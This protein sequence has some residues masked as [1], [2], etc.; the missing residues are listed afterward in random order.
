MMKDTKESGA[1][2]NKGPKKPL[3]IRI[4]EREYLR[5]LKLENYPNTPALTAELSELERAVAHLKS[6][7][8]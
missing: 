6:A 8:V 7:A 5:R 4:L 1:P 3:P 2:K